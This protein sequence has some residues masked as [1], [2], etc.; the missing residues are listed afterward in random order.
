MLM[1]KAIARSFCVCQLVSE[2]VYSSYGLDV[3]LS[4]AVNVLIQ[5][6]IVLRV[7]K[8]PLAL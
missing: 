8:L 4:S 3:R 1:T 5:A 6:A 2:P 7:A